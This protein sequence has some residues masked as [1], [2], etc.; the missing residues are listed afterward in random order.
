[1]K[2]AILTACAVCLFAGLA[3]A[4]DKPNILFVIA[5]QWRSS[6]F[7]FAGD[8]NVHT[9]H[10]DSL[11]A[12]SV[13]FLN[14]VSSMPVC[15]PMRAS[16]QTGQRALTHGLFMNDQPL[17]PN[18]VTLAKVLK[19]AGYDTG[20]IG[21]WHINGGNRSGF[22][23]RERR[24]GYDYWKVLEC[25]HQYN[26]SSYYADGPELL[27]WKGYDAIAQTKDAQQYLADHAKADKPFCLVLA[28]GPPH[29]PYGEAPPKYRALYSPNQ[30]R[31]RPNV[32]AS[33]FARARVSQAGYYC[34]LYT[35]PSPRD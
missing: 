9:P 31:L 10:L 13:D 30:I 27:K 32:P 20:F 25:T 26:N 14:A 2:K 28:W 33:L 11:H 23:P 7:G 17:D 5:D 24:Q 4:A 6:A 15:T 1:M 29:D 18:A 12:E 21:K 16:M 19:Q 35:S 8:P 22:I 3:A 34:L